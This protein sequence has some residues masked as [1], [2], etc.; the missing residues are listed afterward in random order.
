MIFVYN[1]KIII[2]KGMFMGEFEININGIDKI[3]HIVTRLG[4]ENTNIEYIYYNVDGEK[5][6]NNDCLLFSSRIKVNEDGTE[7]II[8]I[9]NEEEK[10]IAFELFSNAFKNLKI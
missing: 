8:E 10:K 9:E 7:E 5:N 6:T 2:E 1:K 3:A 4:L